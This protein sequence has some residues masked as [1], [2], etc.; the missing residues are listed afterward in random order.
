M[1]R[2]GTTERSKLPNSAFAYI[3]SRGRRA[4]PIHDEAHV[5]NALAR[6]GQVAFEDDR[7]REQARKRLLNAAKRFRIVPVGFIAGQ[8]RSERQLGEA[9]GRSP[10]KLPSGFVTM[11]MSDIEGSTA[12]VQRLGDRYRELIDGLRDLLRTT[13]VDM[14][15]YVVEARA[16]DF[17]ATFECPTD[18]LEAAVAIQRQLRE[19]TWA[20]DHTVRVR[21]G[22][23]SGYPT[24]TEDNYIGLAVHTT[25]RVCALAHGAQIVVTGD[26]REA[27]QG[28]RPDGLRFRSLGQHHLRGLPEMVPLYQ[29]I[30]PGLIARFP[31]P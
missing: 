8:L 12:L 14:D 5:R 28:S 23:H 7:A 11:L 1:A 21:I 29:V 9:L 3:D 13:T 27:T 24:N 26:T 16:D 4:L 17:F 30:A 6:F 19:R 15:G 18:A 25:S 10:V 31:S 22:I 20:D 2:L